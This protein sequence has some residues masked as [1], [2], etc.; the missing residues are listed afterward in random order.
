MP[1][2]PLQT[3]VLFLVFNRPETTKQVF[4]A[5]RQ[6]KPPRLYVAADGPRVNREGE[7]ER[8][9]QVREI[10]TAVDWPCEVKTL[11]RDENLGCKY[12]VSSAISWFFENESQGI[13]LEDDCLP[14]QSFFWYCEELLIKYKEDESVY[15]ISG[16][17]RGSDFIQLNG[18][19][20]FCKYPLIWGWASWRRVWQN[21]DV[22]ISDWPKRR[23]ILS[24]KISKSKD[25]TRF[26]MTVF[27]KMYKRKINTW[28]YQFVYLHL[29]GNGLC[30]VP[31]KNLVS[32]IGF[33]PDA[34]HTFIVDV[35][36]NRVLHEIFTPL[37]HSA[38][39]NS[40]ESVNL[41]FESNIFFQKN[42]VFRFHRKIIQILKRLLSNK[43][44]SD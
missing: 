37:N 38:T 5:I 21:Y 15:S 16:D 29:V 22:E 34:T 13:I 4:E 10:A 42:I 25:A 28:D 44:A 36:S 9:S 27:S 7:A 3:A 40:S 6:A 20:T 41:F 11:F 1:Q 14:S 19:Y 30:I 31:R 17:S 26:W 2:A 33:G 23:N 18:D 12:A 8:A 32:N 39:N 24:K 35:N 43:N